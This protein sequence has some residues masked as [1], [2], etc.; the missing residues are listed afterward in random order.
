MKHLI[1]A[2]IL[3]V[4]SLLTDVSHATPEATPYTPDVRLLSSL[5]R[6]VGIEFTVADF[7]K[8]GVIINGETFFHIRLT[9]ETYT[10]DVGCPEL[11]VI[12]RSIMVPLDSKLDLRVTARE[13]QDI[14]LPVAPSKGFIPMGRD[15]AD[16]SCKFGEPYRVNA[17]YPD[18]PVRMGEPYIFRDVRGV[19]VSVCPFAYNP[20]SKTL[21]VYHRL[22]IVI[23][24]RTVNEHNLEWT[25]G[26]SASNRFFQTLYER[27]FLN[28]DASRYDPLGDRGRMIVISHGDFLTVMQPYVDWKNQ[29]GIETSMVDVAAV[30]STAEEIKS[31]IEIQYNQNDGLT[32]VQFAG[33]YPQIP[34]FLMD[35]DFCDGQ[36]TSDAAY[37]LLDGADSY[38][39]IF[40]GRFS[41]DTAAELT[42]QIERTIWYERDID[43]GEWLHKAIGLASAWGEGYGYM[44][45][46]DRD[47]ME[48]LR[49]ML[50]EYTYTEVDQLYEWGE[51]PFSIIP[52]PVEDYVNAINAG[53]S[54]INTMSHAD[55][56]S[57]FSIP[58]GDFEELFRI[59]DIAELENDYRL[60]LLYLGAPYLANF[61]IDFCYPEAW[62][63][64][65][66]PDTNAPV[67]AVAVYASSVDLDYASPGAAQHETVELLTTDAYHSLGGLLYNGMCYSMDIYGDRGIKTFKS[68]HIFGDATLQMRTD[69]PEF[70]TIDHAAS[71][72]LGTTAFTVST[73]VEDSL[74]CLS[75][76]CRIVAVDYTDADGDVT[77]TF[78]PFSEATYL[79]LTV[80]AFNKITHVELVP[81]GEPGSPSPSATPSGSATPTPMPPTGTV[82]LPPTTS[83]PSPPTG[84]PFP[85]TATPAPST[86]NTPS[87]PTATPVETPVPPTA[88]PECEILGVTLWMPLD[89][90]TPGDPCAC[91]V[92]VCNPGPDVY[93]NVPLFVILDVYGL[94]FFAPMFSGFDY[95]TLVN[96]YPGESEIEVLPEFTWPDGA[97][98]AS[99][100]LWYAAMTDIGFTRLFGEMDT[101]AF[102][103]GA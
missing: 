4:P 54:L 44:G 100:I 32:F 23:G 9:G 3:T 50:L 18:H 42:P 72:P 53:R 66:N 25:R 27:H 8:T 34:S 55:C 28:Y 73:G 11:P 12:V 22:E 78:D 14:H 69:T 40:V 90:F 36:G 101:F 60:P 80:T 58:P 19:A 15:P 47:L 87:P 83:T 39:E 81:V 24:F 98:S 45:L 35:R 68:Y 99:G 95:Y 88:T 43:N 46:R 37:S 70:M 30:G 62:M 41:A 71:I 96:L 33:D 7:E 49:L 92:T 31:F 91:L 13:Y 5:E 10:R 103:W 86:T 82:T 26:Q 52:V 89:Y 94:Y 93:S 57:T 84:T 74:V 29:K 97:G 1:L 21:R 38:P 51:P 20:V 77:L 59:G 79:T 65:V 76:S 75:E 16:I 56:E 85:P 2:F 63:I 67:G 102:G 48:Q 17:F 64:A 6:G 61:Q